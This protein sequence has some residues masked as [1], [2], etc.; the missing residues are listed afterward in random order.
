MLPL[1]TVSRH[2]HQPRT[3]DDVLVIG[4]R[5]RGNVRA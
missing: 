3:D 1:R 5:R 2:V 4:T